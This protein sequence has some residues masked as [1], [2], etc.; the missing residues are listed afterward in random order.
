MFAAN[1]APPNLLDGFEGHFELGTER[2]KRKEGRENERK[3][4]ERNGREKT[5]QNKFMVI[6]HLLRT[7]SANKIKHTCRP[8]Q[9]CKK[10]KNY[11]IYKT[12]KRL[13]YAVSQYLP[14]TALN[15]SALSVYLDCTV[16]PCCI[17]EPTQNQRLL[18][19]VNWFSTISQ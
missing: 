10:T 19:S 8:M 5:L 14:D 12:I 15:R 7:E 4:T 3:G 9:Y 18:T 11:T 1:S 6:E 13:H 2:G 17:K 16:S